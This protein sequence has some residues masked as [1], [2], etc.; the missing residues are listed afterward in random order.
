[1]KFCSDADKNNTVSTTSIA[2]RKT[3]GNDKKWVPA[4]NYRQPPMFFAC[5]R[6]P[7]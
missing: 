6:A 1:M 7:S 3:A 4:I 2:Q 5:C